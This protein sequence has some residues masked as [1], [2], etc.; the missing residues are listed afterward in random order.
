MG[1]SQE[2]VEALMALAAQ[3]YSASICASH[4][5]GMSRNAAVGL[6]HRRGF[7][8]FGNSGGKGGGAATIPKEQRCKPNA[9]YTRKPKPTIVED[10]PIMELPRMATLDELKFNDCRYM[11]GMPDDPSHRYC[12]AEGFPYCPSH[13]ALCYETVN[14]RR[15]RVSQEPIRTGTRGRISNS[16]R[17]G[18][19]E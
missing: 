13:R 6:A 15:A 14:Q 19:F 18:G 17:H 1:W 12:G 4:F 5:E 8:F 10:A 16:I 7:Q 3:G 2:V 9:H 11:F